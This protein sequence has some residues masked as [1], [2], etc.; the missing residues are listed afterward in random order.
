MCVW[1]NSYCSIV[2]TCD[3]FTAPPIPKLRKWV[4][5][6]VHKVKIGDRVCYCFSYPE[7]LKIKYRR[8]GKNLMWT[9]CKF[10]FK[11]SFSPSMKW[12]FP[13]TYKITLKLPIFW[14]D[15]VWMLSVITV[16]VKSWYGNMNICCFNWLIMVC[17]FREQSFGFYRW[18]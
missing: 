11:S 12:K 10:K 1:G 7:H 2:G 6:G 18:T 17:Q 13:Q 4:P 16:S 14:L 9:L 8:C 5:V 15:I 3:S